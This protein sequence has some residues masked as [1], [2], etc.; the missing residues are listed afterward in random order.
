MVIMMPRWKADELGLEV[1]AKHV[2][3]SFVGVAPRVMGIGPVVA[4]P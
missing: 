3:T 1:L 4:I 2:A